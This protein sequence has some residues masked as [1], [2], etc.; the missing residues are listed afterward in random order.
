MEKF[1]ADALAFL[2]LA[3]PVTVE[4]EDDLS[5]ED[6]GPVDGLCY[7]HTE[8]H[9]IYVDRASSRGLKATI[10]H[11]LTHA[12]VSEQWGEAVEFHGEEFRASAIWIQEAMEALGHKFAAPVF[13]VDYDK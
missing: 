11:E 6:F 1:I 7:C 9:E 12:Y 3:R 10:A 13:L 4:I 5:L 8:S 2:E